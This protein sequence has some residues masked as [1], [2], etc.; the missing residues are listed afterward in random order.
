MKKLLLLFLLI[1]SYTFA[2]EQRRDIEF[3][4]NV[5]RQIVEIQ[6]VEY[7]TD[8]NLLDP[9]NTGDNFPVVTGITTN[10]T[11]TTVGGTITMMVSATDDNGI[12]RY[13]FK[14]DMSG[15][16]SISF[17]H[18]TSNT[19]TAH[20]GTYQFAEAGT[21]RTYVYVTDTSGQHILA[22]GPSILVTEN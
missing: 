3:C 7:T 8:I 10:A 1:G 11:Q 15:S 17:S 22:W 19:P 6:G 18:Y 2:Q 21:W 9:N 20:I 16:T 5:D 14:S 12:R 13:N 4:W